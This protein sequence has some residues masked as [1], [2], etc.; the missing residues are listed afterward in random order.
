MSVQ[1]LPSD[2][3][4]NE[5]LTFRDKSCLEINAQMRDENPKVYS[6]TCKLAVSRK[7]CGVVDAKRRLGFPQPAPV[8]SFK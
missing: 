7:F 2:D 3:T 1:P 8:R 6:E 4:R 5:E